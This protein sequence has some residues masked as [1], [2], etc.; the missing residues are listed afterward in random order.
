MMTTFLHDGELNVPTVNDVLNKT[1]AEVREAT[2]ENWQIVERAKEKRFAF[3][4]KIKTAYAYE[5]YL[6]VG[7]MG[8]WQMINFYK[9]SSDCSINPVNN[10]DVVMAFLLGILTGVNQE[11]RKSNGN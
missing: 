9:E 8:P 2:G 11:R 6:Y 10:A 3:N 7:G 4:T 1:L 5:L